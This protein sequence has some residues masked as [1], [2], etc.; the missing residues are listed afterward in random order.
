MHL[1]LLEQSIRVAQHGVQGHATPRANLAIASGEGPQD[2]ALLLRRFVCI[3]A[4]HHDTGPASLRDD[5]RFAGLLHATENLRGVL[6]QIRDRHDS[7][8]LRHMYLQM[9]ALRY[10]WWGQAC[11]PT[12]PRSD[13]AFD[14]TSRER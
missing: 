13:A 4:E 3:D 7:R 1:V 6:S 5:H 14:A 11:N 8:D 10:A 2:L 12:A 9:Y